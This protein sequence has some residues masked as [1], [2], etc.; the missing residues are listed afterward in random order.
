VTGDV[1]DVLQVAFLL[2]PS[3]RVIK[4][5]SE[6]QVGSDMDSDGVG[7]AKIERPKAY[8]NSNV[9]NCLQCVQKI[10]IAGVNEMLVDVNSA[11]AWYKGTSMIRFLQVCAPL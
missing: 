8:P 6:F 7:E 10:N 9:C 5:R 1:G 4:V 2:W 11:L 3:I